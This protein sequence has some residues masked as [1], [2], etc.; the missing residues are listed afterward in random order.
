M[1]YQRWIRKTAIGKFGFPFPYAGITQIRF[2]GVI[3]GFT[4]VKPPL[5]ATVVKD[6]LHVKSTK[7]IFICQEQ[8]S[9][10]Q[11]PDLLPIRR[12][13]RLSDP[14]HFGDHERNQT[15]SQ[16]KQNSKQD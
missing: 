3:S 13:R 14:Y 10:Y 8:S 1:L 12:A 7:K 11:R 6:L 4:E 15:D 5:T 9:S 16:N 2:K